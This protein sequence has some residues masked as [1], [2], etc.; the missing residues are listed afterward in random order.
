MLLVSIKEEDDKRAAIVP[1]FVEKFKSLGIDVEIEKNIAEKINISDEEYIKAGALINKDKNDLLKKADILLKVTK[2]SIKE[3]KLLKK[4]AITISFLDPFF[5]E[6]LIEELL[7]H[8]ITAF[9]MQLIP[10]TTIAQ[11]MDALSSQANLAGYASI[12]TGAKHLNRILPM[13]TTPAGTISPAKVFVIGAGVAGLQAIA[14]AR[15]L[16]AKVEAFDTR[17]I[18]EEQ[19]KSLGAKFLKIDLGKTEEEKGGYAKELTKEQLELQKKAMIKA[20]SSSDMVI[21]TAQIFGKKAPLIISKDMIK[22]M[23]K[24]SVIIDMA[25][26]SGGNVEGSKAD[27]IIDINGIKIIAPKNPTDDVA[28][29]AS[30]VYSSNLY[31]LVEHFFDKENKKT[32]INLEDEILKSSIV[33]YQGKIISPVLQKG[34][35]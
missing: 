15:R 8:N 24:G 32:K 29:D 1:K 10:R 26:T 25:I 35:I 9:S 33:T 5:E 11:K 6:D 23:T 4:D 22:D 31:S 12:I 7:T 20:I 17:P 14:T 3:I 27:E 18:V 16:G 21:T 13:M 28:K 34:K 2:P 30:F 19:I